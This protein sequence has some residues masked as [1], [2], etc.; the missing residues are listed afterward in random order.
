MKYKGALICTDRRVCT[1]LL[2]T[3]KFLKFQVKEE[4][5]LPQKFFQTQNDGLRINHE[6]KNI[7]SIPIQ[8]VMPS[9]LK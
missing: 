6:A 2:K 8:H 1:L 5:I 4:F 3:L 7:Y 9:V